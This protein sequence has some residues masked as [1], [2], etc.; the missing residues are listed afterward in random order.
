VPDNDAGAERLI[1]CAYCGGP[2]VICGGTVRCAGVDAT[3]RERR[4]ATAV[5]ALY[6]GLVLTPTPAALWGGALVRLAQRLG[7]G[8]PPADRGF[9]TIADPECA[10]SGVGATDHALAYLECRDLA[11][12]GDLYRAL[13]A[14]EAPWLMTL[15]RFGIDAA[16]LTALGWMGPGL[17][18]VVCDA[19]AEPGVEGEPLDGIAVGVD[20]YDAAI[21]CPRCGEI[22]EHPLPG[23][24]RRELHPVGRCLP[25]LSAPTACQ[26]HEGQALDVNGLCDTGRRTVDRGVLTLA[27]IGRAS[28]RWERNLVEAFARAR[29][30]EEQAQRTDSAIVR[31]V[32]T[33]PA[34]APTFAAL[35]QTNPGAARMLR[36]IGAPDLGPA[37]PAMVA[38]MSDEGLLER[39]LEEGMEKLRAL[40]EPRPKARSSSRTQGKGGGR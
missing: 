38:R 1:T 12:L 34:L 31:A 32:V 29:W 36:E 3:A 28:N 24:K 13:Q 19:C 9:L 4:W 40:F 23:V 37:D 30:Y 10:I 25:G 27:T 39:F 22:P 21:R 2:K 7:R 14:S 20:V 17:F 8:T 16:L 15:W 33:S 35:A 11:R 26:A 18:A 6:G 5:R